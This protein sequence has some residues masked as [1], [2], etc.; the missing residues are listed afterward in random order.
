MV[1]IKER[2]V[3]WL[4]SVNDDTDTLDGQYCQRTSLDGTEVLNDLDETSRESTCADLQ[5]AA[6]FVVDLVVVGIDA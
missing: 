6:E 3:I 4:T 5:P 2:I 1:I